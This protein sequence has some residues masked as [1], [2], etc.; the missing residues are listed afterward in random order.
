M[1]EVMEKLDEIEG[2]DRA[3]AREVQP[4]PVRR[5]GGTG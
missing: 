1:T 2:I 4:P 5:Y 3:V